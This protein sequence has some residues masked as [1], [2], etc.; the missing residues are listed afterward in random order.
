MYYFR[1]FTL[2]LHHYTSQPILFYTPVVTK[3][4]IDPL[5]ESCARSLKWAM[6]LPPRL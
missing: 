6:R 1:I 5:T 3:M 4:G 2:Y